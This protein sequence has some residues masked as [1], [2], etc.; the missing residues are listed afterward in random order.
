M[1]HRNASGDI[2]IANMRRGIL[3]LDNDRSI[4]PEV[5]EFDGKPIRGCNDLCFDHA[6]NLYFTATAGS[7]ASK[8]AGEVFC[9]LASGEVRR[10]AYG[11]AF[12]NG[13]AV[14]D[15]GSRVFVAET[16]DCSIHLI[17]LEGPGAVRRCS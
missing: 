16:F 9:R 14:S 17:E 3:R 5:V 1:L 10:M 12:C 11:L 7:S 15:D 6:G 13:I 8:P 4:R 2:W